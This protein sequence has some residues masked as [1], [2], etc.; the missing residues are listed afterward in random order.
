MENIA[1]KGECAWYQNLN[2]WADQEFLHYRT[3]L[4]AAQGRG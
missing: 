3:E 1:E 4:G 2:V